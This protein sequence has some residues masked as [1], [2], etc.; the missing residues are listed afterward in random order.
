MASVLLI[1][2][3]I[4]VFAMPSFARFRRTYEFK[5]ARDNI[6]AQVQMARAKAIA[7]G[8]DQPI[9]FYAGSFGFDGHLHPAGATTFTG[10]KLPPGVVY[11]WPS[12]SPM[13]VTMLRDGRANSSLVIP[14]ANAHGLCDTVQVLASG[15][16]LVQ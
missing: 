8:I 1:L 3:L 9:H 2:G 5:G 13:A 15:L 6:I 4:F 12:G 16:V 14:I 7:S 11:Q 10:W